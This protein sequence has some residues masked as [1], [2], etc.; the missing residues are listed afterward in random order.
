MK[1]LAIE[2]SFDDTSI[3]IMDNHN[4]L[5]MQTY[6]QIK[7]HVSTGGVVPEKASRLH[8]ENIFF[9]IELAIKDSNVKLNEL[10]AIVVTK[11]PGLV[12]T[13]QV[14]IVVAKTLSQSLKIPLYG[15]NHM[16]AHIYSSFINKPLTDIPEKALVLLVSGGHTT[17]AMIS[18]GEISILGETKDDAV[19][20]AFD[21]VGKLLD[22]GY[23]G[24]PAVDKI[25]N[26]FT[27]ELFEIPV[28]DL[29]GYD[30]SYSGIKSFVA[31]KK[32]LVESHALAAGFQ[33]AAIDQLVNKVK[34]AILKRKVNTLIIGGGVAT[35]TYL[36]S[37]LS[38][39]DI[40]IISPRG[41]YALDN[42]AMIGY[43]AYYMI[44]NNMIK[45]EKLT[46][47]ASS[48]LKVGK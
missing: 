10:D 19:G 11:G 15:V 23:P 2:T 46:L 27:R 9:L 6:S 8:S 29:P 37:E 33:K 45:P 35:N 41:I 14:G 44:E 48:N 26:E 40:S 16:T 1:I 47:D 7:E 25:F 17:L 30:F 13:L 34:K 4:V 42:A 43:T 20:E 18:S 39:L 22:L 3:A 36:K 24:G 38:S 12:N 28:P 32:G 21:K 5:S 31:N